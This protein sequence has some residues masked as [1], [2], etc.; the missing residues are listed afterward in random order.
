[1]P[2]PIHWMPTNAPTGQAL[3]TLKAIT[4]GLTET[5]LRYDEPWLAEVVFTKGF[6]P[7]A[8]RHWAY[9]AACNCED[10]AQAASS[11]GSG[12]AACGR[13]SHRRS[14]LVC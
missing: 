6:M 14:H 11:P 3:D 5:E 13:P 10:L 12:S 4:A 9:G 7:Y 1:M 8:K 2:C